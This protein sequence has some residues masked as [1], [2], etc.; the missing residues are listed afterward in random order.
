MTRDRVICA[1]AGDSRALAGL[2]NG[3]FIELSKDHKPNNK[4]E[5]KRIK[6]AGGFVREQRV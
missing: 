1:N 3:N 6:A 4:G 5:L 2:K